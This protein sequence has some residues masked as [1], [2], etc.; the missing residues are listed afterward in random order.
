[1]SL[2]K[3]FQPR[4]KLGMAFE[5]GC[6]EDEETIAIGKKIIDTIVDFHQGKELPNQIDQ[7]KI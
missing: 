4:L 1:M 3:Y 5:C 2:L 7:M 6:H